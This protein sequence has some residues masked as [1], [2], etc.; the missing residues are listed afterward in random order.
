VEDHPG[1]AELVSEHCKADGEK[2]FLHRHEDLTAIG[3]QGIDAFRLVYAL[4][5]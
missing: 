3:E 5:D 1:C 4:D 2:G